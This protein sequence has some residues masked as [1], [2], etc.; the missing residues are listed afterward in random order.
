V[1]RVKNLLRRL[2]PD[3]LVRR[4]QHL[5]Y[6]RAH[7]DELTTRQLD[8]SRIELIRSASLEQL[9][10]PAYLEKELLP[11]LGLNDEELGDIPKRLHQYAGYGLFHWQLPNQFS[12]YLVDLSGQRIESYLEIGFRHGGTFLITVEYL[13]RFHPLRRAVALDPVPSQSMEEYAA[14][15]EGVTVLET[16]SQTPEFAAFL[17]DQEPF[18]LVLIDGDHSEEACSSD[19]ELVK[20]HARRVVFHDIVSHEVPGVG[21][22]WSDVKRRYSDRITEYT[23]QYP[24]QEAAGAPQFGLGLVE[25]RSLGFT[26]CVVLEAL[27][28]AV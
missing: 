22:V 2:L 25:I 4:I 15:R 19:F 16:T 6:V 9:S 11:R 24:E 3:A 1:R 5:L 17:R 20:D 18:D 23:D 10:D 26:A 7:R 8:L 28:A 27:G 14:S 12:K 13:N 21:R